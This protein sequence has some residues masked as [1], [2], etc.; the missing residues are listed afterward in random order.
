LAVVKTPHTDIRIKGS[1]PNKLIELLLQEY[2]KSVKITGDN[3]DEKLDV[4]RTDWY[5]N[6]KKKLTPGAYL[7][8]FRQNSHMTQADLGK[9]IG[10]LPRQHVS[11]MENGSRR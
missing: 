6:I 5:R 10:G 4:F 8:I 3:P 11:N 1:I 7:R 9:A 2:G